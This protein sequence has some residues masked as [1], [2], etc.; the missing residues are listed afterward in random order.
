MYLSQHWPIKQIPPS[1]QGL[2]EH[3]PAPSWNSQAVG[4]APTALPSQLPT[5]PRP[6]PFGSRPSEYHPSLLCPTPCTLR[7]LSLQISHVVAQDLD[8][9]PSQILQYASITRGRCV[10]VTRMQSKHMCTSVQPFTTRCR[11]KDGRPACIKSSYEC[12]HLP[13]A[14]NKEIFSET[15]GVQTEA[16]VRRLK[17][18]ALGNTPFVSLTQYKK[19]NKVSRLFFCILTVDQ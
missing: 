10:A 16:Q 3:R 8:R 13:S 17:K 9:L 18:A 6:T 12:S 2:G 14:S 19:A 5:P 11:Q 1:A 7:N 4:P 15:R